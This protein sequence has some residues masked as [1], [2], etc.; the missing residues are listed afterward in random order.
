MNERK[1]RRL[2][3]N[4]SESAVAV[5]CA[6]P[7]AKPVE[8]APAL[9]GTTQGEAP[10]IPRPV[11]RFTRCGKRLLDADNLAAS[12]K[13]LLDGLRHA[14]CIVND[15]PERIDFQ[16]RQR[17]ISQGEEAHTMIEIF[18]EPNPNDDN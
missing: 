13:D 5:N 1:F 12:F 14:H 8:C 10:R 15:S 17:K 16:A 7:A 18:Y 2:F 9:D 4:A 3:P 11:V 6:L